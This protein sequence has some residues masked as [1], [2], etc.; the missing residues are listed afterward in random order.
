MKLT[1]I[2]CNYADPQGLRA[3]PLVDSCAH[4]KVPLHLYGG[5]VW[6]ECRK[7]KLEYLLPELIQLQSRGWTHV[8][9]I[10]AFDS[11]VLAEYPVICASYV[12]GMDAPRL[13]FSAEKNCFPY[14]SLRE[15][16]PLTRSRWRYLCAGGWIGEIEYMRS[17]IP[18]A[19][20][21][22]DSNDD[23]GV[24]TR[25]FVSGLLPEAKLD[26]SCLIFQ[27]MHSSPEPCV[28]NK[29]LYNPITQT[30]PC[31][32]HFNGGCG[33]DGSFDEIRRDLGL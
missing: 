14:A 28:K 4:Y 6:P 10:D 21:N 24:W 8:M 16:Y 7:A 1:A 32:V 23:Q 30:M 12:V 29:A 18:V 19:L 17:V 25:A 26:D 9:W 31:T 27:N 13:L 2:S 5:P 22:S 20:K 15:K 11:L 3:K 33:L